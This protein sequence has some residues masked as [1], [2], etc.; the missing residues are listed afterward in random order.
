MDKMF[1]I[2]APPYDEGSAGI[3]ALHR[4]THEL[5]LKGEKAVIHVSH[6]PFGRGGGYNKK[7]KTPIM[8]YPNAIAIYPEITFGNPLGCEVAA[9]LI[10]HIPGYWG[11]PIAFG[12]DVLWIFSNYWNKISK[13]NLPTD[14]ILTVPTI[15]VD[16]FPCYALSRNKKYFFRGKGKQP[17]NPRVQ[18]EDL[19]SGVSN[20]TR[21]NT[22]VER[23]NNAEILYSYDNVSALNWIALLCGCPVVLIPDPLYSK[24]DLEEI[25][26]PG[27]GY[28][29]EEEDK[30]RS[31]LNVN[32]IREY[33]IEEYKM[34]QNQL[35]VFIETMK[36]F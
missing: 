1:I 4:L 8:Q 10:M 7:W 26:V 24:E 6:D 32:K 30:A 33:F 17:N 2:Y 15:E 28:G 9:R 16:K 13:L 29:I 20:E 22:L 3:V 23:L 21:H 18:G 14:R 27:M 12:N 35:T 36:S 19:F 5:Q 34:F 31:T 25:I 11:G